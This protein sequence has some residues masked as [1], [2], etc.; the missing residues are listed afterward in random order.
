MTDA[1]AEMHTAQPDA[2]PDATGAKITVPRHRLIV[3]VTHWI[4]VLA[5]VLMLMSGLN[6]FNAHPALYW[7]QYSDFDRPWLS[8]TAEKGTPHDHGVLQIGSAQFWTTGVLGASKEQGVWTN[9][10]FPEEV[11]LPGQTALSNARHWHFF[12]AWVFGLNGATYLISG[13]INRHL[14]RDLIPH[15]KDLRNLWKDVVDHVKLNFHKGW[16]STRYGPLQRIAYAG[17]A[18]VVLPLIVLTGM[19]MSPGLDAAFPFLPWVFGGRQSAR[20]IHFLCAFASVGF[21]FIHLAMVVLTGPINQVKGMILGKFT[22]I[23]DG[24]PEDAK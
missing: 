9:R 4:N 23:D 7:G 18:L 12:W 16:A 10:G 1:A 22:I 15:K 14:K 3:R 13:L 8:M 5:F 21:I 17:I 2:M 6:I 11:T 19:T 24:H 20:S